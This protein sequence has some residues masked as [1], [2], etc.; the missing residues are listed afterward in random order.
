MS[1][2][3]TFKGMTNENTHKYRCVTMADFA[4]DLII[5]LN[6]MYTPRPYDAINS[7]PTMYEDANALTF[8]TDAVRSIINSP[9]TSLILPCKKELTALLQVLEQEVCTVH[10]RSQDYLFDIR[11]YGVER[12]Q[13]IQKR[14]SRIKSHLNIFIFF[15]F[16][17]FVFKQLTYCFISFRSW[18]MNTICF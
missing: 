12:K 8:Y 2:N 9:K 14:I 5:V 18:I 17:G 3:L 15:K 16:W 4:Y 10:W 11:E 7:Y 6:R 13:A 1:N